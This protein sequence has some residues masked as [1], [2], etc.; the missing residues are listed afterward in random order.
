MKFKI[1]SFPFFYLIAIVTLLY[2][3]HLSYGQTIIDS[4]TYFYKAITAPEAPE[5]LPL[6]INYYTKKKQVDLDQNDTLNAISDLRLLAIG[7]FKIGNYYDSENHIVEALRLIEPMTSKDT[8]IDARVGLYNQLGRI[9]NA[10]HNPDAAIASFDSALAISKKTRDSI[11]IL[12][13][14]ANTYLELEDYTNAIAIYSLLYKKSL[15]NQN[16][17]Q[18]A[19]VLDNLGDVQSR[20]GSSDALKN[21]LAALRMRKDKNY[22]AGLYSSYKNLA[23]HYLRKNEKSIAKYYADS[24]LGVSKELN[25]SSYKL[26]ALSFFMN[27]NEDEMVREY[28][29]LS[30]SVTEA[31]QLAENKN[32]FLKYNVAEE[33]KK[34]QASKL[35]QEIESRKRL[36]YQLLMV[37]ILMALIA[38]FFIFR[39]RYRKAKIEEVYKTETRIAKKV[40]DEVANDMYK[41]MTSLENNPGIATGVLDELEKIYSK[42]R[43]ISRENSAIDL[44]QNYGQQLNDLLL[45]YKNHRVTVVTLNLL[46]M[47]WEE[48][49]EIKKTAIYRVLQEL[50]TNMR[51]HSGA[52]SVALIFS[53]EGSRIHINY[54]DNGV[55]CNL[56]KQNGLQNTETRIASINGSISFES[57]KGAGFKATLIV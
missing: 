16:S 35:L 50:M 43:D 23:A 39:Y 48:V 37:F 52:S 44:D 53:K 41:V 33:Q 1:H 31:K 24:A 9:Y 30:D 18:T 3:S 38:S 29:R 55:G 45:G 5:N 8:L 26:D 51:K 54:S 15:Q 25:S 57:R 32:A 12:N 14:K 47:D 34:T 7:E 28:K 2:T 46:K 4:S 11:I 19:L 36:L 22:L 56:I 21:L 17:L 10:A 6:G 27:T 40:H 20:T 42:T 49:S 13:N